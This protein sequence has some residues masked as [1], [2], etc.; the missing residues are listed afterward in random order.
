VHG[1]KPKYYHHVVGI[2]SRLDALQAAILSIKLKHLNDW[3]AARLRNANRYNEIFESAGSKTSATLLSEG[4]LPLRTPQGVSDPSR[5]IYNQ[6]C[7]R[8]PDGIRDQ[9][10]D[11]MKEQGIGTEIYYPVPLH[12]Q[13]CFASLGYKLGDLPESESAA[14]E[15]L[16]LPIYPE[17]SEE[18]QN[19]VAST[20]CKF[21]E[22]HAPAKV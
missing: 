10:R 12:E 14:R 6:Y 21:V 4:G 8:V 16:A 9:L 20:V 1:G 5:H 11:H 7:I 19:H 13:A 17:L 18:Q 2:N 22:E 3:H 15:T